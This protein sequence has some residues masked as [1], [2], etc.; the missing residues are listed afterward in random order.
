MSHSGDSMLY[1]LA[2]FLLLY[3]VGMGIYL[4]AGQCRKWL[5]RRREHRRE[6]E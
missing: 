2:A 1:G 5:Q 4:L 6:E 3:V